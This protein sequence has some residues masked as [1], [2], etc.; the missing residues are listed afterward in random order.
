[1]QDDRGYFDQEAEEDASFLDQARPGR[2]YPE[3]CLLH[4]VVVLFEMLDETRAQQSEKGGP[5]FSRFELIPI[6]VQI[7]RNPAANY[8]A[9]RLILGPGLLS[10][11]ALEHTDRAAILRVKHA[12]N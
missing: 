8:G 12:T 9:L 4:L 6:D 5:N 11:L 1:L 7:P 2:N 10:A 3:E